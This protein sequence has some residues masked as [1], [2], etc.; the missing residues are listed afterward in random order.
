MTPAAP[1]SAPALSGKTQERLTRG[2]PPAQ[3]HPS[4]AWLCP[5]RH[6]SFAKMHG[7]PLKLDETSPP[8][9]ALFDSTPDL[10]PATREVG[11]PIQRMAE[12][13]VIK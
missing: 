10:D 1:A 5:C 12:F 9:R 2:T 7:A 11:D 6:G 4:Y 3:A 8:P 13:L